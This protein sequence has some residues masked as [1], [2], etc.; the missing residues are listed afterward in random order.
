MSSVPAAVSDDGSTVVGTSWVNNQAHAFRWR[1]ATG[2][3]DLW[4]AENT[5]ASPIQTSCDGSVILTELTQTF[6]YVRWVDGVGQ[7]PLLCTEAGFATNVAGM[8]ADG[9]VIVGTCELGSFSGHTDHAVYW[10]GSSSSSVRFG[11][12]L[13]YGF[14]VSAD[15]HIFMGQSVD[16]VWDGAFLSMG[17]SDYTKVGPVEAE[18]MKL[19]GDGTS[20]AG[21]EYSGAAFRWR[22]SG[23]TTVPCGA[24]HKSCVPTAVNADG[25]VIV[26]NAAPNVP[27]IWTEKKGTVSFVT[28][29]VAAGAKLGTWTALTVADMTADARVFTG[30][31]SDGSGNS[32]AYRLQ[33]PAGTF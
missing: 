18:P 2:M 9:S 3:Q 28:A 1:K 33:V 12:I 11:N 25:S 19:S 15:G 10:L 22:A 21:N 6:D 7:T 17:G 26:L 30:V 20:I 32:V 4:T 23:T 14:D 29:V 16:P 5:L 13:A 31:A 24:G 8:S 27:V